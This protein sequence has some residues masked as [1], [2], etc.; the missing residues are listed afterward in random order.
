[1]PKPKRELRVFANPYSALD[2]EGRPAGA[3]PYD[4]IEHHGD[5]L[6]YVGAT[7]HVKKIA[8]AHPKGLHGVIH[9]RTWDYATEATTIPNT[10]HYRRGIQHGD[11][12]PADL[13]THMEAGLPRET[14]RDPIEVLREKRAGALAHHEREHGETPDGLGSHWADLLDSKP[15]AA[16]KSWLA[17]GE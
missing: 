10:L 12:V 2:H 17:K 13:E 8:D 7:R 6:M 4:P 1:M 15:A 11:L 14:F 3:Y 9:D 5:D 16:P